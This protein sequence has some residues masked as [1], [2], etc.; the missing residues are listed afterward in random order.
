MFI[1][2]LTYGGK[3]LYLD[4]IAVG[5]ELEKNTDLVQTT[6]YVRPKITTHAV[7]LFGQLGAYPFFPNVRTD[8]YS[9][10]VS[11]SVD[12]GP[13]LPT[14]LSTISAEAYASLTG[15][16][17]NELTFVQTIKRNYVEVPTPITTFTGD[18]Q[19]LLDW[20][21]RPE[22]GIVLPLLPAEIGKNGHFA[23][24]ESAELTY[25]YTDTGTYHPLTFL[26]GHATSLVFEGHG[27]IKASLDLG[28]DAE[29]L[30]VATGIAWRLAVR[31][32]L[33]AKLT[34]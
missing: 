14:I 3:A 12:G 31:A 34:F 23:H 5:Q 26:L 29:N 13:G 2:H 10:S 25:N 11:G 22:K 4:N 18:T 19:V 8:E 20:V 32:A 21:V 27:T 15:N 33:E 9:L 28:M 1:L 30:G 24:R 16:S 6:T 7:N 17:E